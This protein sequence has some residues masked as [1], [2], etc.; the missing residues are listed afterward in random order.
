[1]FSQNS[2]ICPKKYEKEELCRMLK[3][4]VIFLPVILEV[5][6]ANRKTEQEKEVLFEEH[7]KDYVI[8]KQKII[9]KFR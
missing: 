7:S 6:Y 9:N 5:N 4:S 2:L 3:I 1:M 8:A